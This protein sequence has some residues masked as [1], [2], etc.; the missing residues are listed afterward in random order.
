MRIDEFLDLLRVD[1]FTSADNHVFQATGDAEVALRRLASEVT[2]VQPALG[3]NRRFGGAGHLV[4]PFH[5]VVTAG[6]EFADLAHRHFPSRFRVDDPAFDLGERP[7]D[8]RDAHLQRVI[9]AAHGAARG[10][11][12][13]P[14]D[15]GDLPHVHLVHNILHDG[16]GAGASGHDARAHVG[17]VRLGKILMLQ[18]GD[19]HG[20]DAVE[21]GDAL[22]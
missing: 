6:D 16:D 7:A 21:A 19:E 2:R 10:G 22:V 17:K 1:V 15:D 9:G 20:G 3:V 14:I 11:L 12:R 18:H 13:L 4:V 8:R 5:D